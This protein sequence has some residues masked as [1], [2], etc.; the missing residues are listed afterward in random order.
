M[1]FHRFPSRARNDKASGYLFGCF[2]ALGSAQ[3]LNTYQ[4][5]FRPLRVGRSQCDLSCQSTHLGAERVCLK[6]KKVIE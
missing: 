6:T 3:C 5:S 2:K 4:V 1:A